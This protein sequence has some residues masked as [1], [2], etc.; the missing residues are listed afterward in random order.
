MGQKTS[1]KL[2]KKT[3]RAI[4]PGFGMYFERVNRNPLA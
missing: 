2:R 4:L 1:T 3:G